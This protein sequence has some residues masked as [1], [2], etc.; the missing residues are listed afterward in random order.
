[1]FLPYFYLPPP[2]NFPSPVQFLIFNSFLIN[3]QYK[4]VMWL[5]IA[6]CSAMKWLTLVLGDCTGKRRE[7][8]FWEEKSLNTNAFLDFVYEVYIEKNNSYVKKRYVPLTRSVA[9]ISCCYRLQVFG[10][11]SCTPATISRIILNALQPHMPFLRETRAWPKSMRL[12]SGG[13]KTSTGCSLHI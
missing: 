1:M 8:G 6:F 9:Q 3:F 10:T 5:H 4:Y 13:L 11:C 7:A 12:L 2:Q